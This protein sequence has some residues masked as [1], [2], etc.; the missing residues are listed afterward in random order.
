MIRRTITALRSLR[1]TLVLILSLSLIFLLGLWIPQK[2]LLTRDL[3]LAWKEGSPRLV[4]FLEALRFTDIYTSPVTL[5][6]W[7]LFFLNLVLV[8]WSRVAVVRAKIG[9]SGSKLE[10]PGSRSRYAIRTS[11]SLTTGDVISSLRGAIE[12]K[13]YRWYGTPQRFYAVKNRLSPLATLLFHLSFLLILLGGVISMYTRF[14]ATVDLAEGEVFTGEMQQY[15]SGSRFPRIG[16]PPA[17]TFLVESITPIVEEDT[18]TGLIVKILDAEGKRHTAEI[19]RPYRKDHTSFVIQDLGVA[20][21][22]ILQDAKGR[23]LDGAFM[24]LSVLRGKQ[25]VFVLEGMEF[26]TEF[27]PDYVVREGREESRSEEVRNPAFRFHI[28]KGKKFIARATARPGQTVAFGAYR[29]V[30]PEMRYWV[31]LY[32]VKERGLGILYAGFGIATAALVWRLLFYRREV[33]G[34]V[35]TENGKPV[36]QLA[37]RAEFY[38]SLFSDEFQVL[39]NS[40]L[41]ERDQ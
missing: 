41:G 26:T 16:S 34:A 27:F 10:D 29:L 37:G 1:F 3:Y 11:I 35:G 12:R 22:I 28:Q 5:A 21:L 32:V 38:T 4:S 7:V 39:K 14:S 36:L 15:N 24:K 13:G 40:I 20:P 9:F 30:C 2:G 8:M 19:N 6:L 23:E 33:I 25:D 31:R 18:P 17:G